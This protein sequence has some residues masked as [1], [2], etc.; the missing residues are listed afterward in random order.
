MA[1]ILMLDTATEVCS[2][3]LS[4]DGMIN[5]FREENEGFRHSE[6]LTVFIGEVLGEAGWTT[7][8]LDAVCVSRGPGSYTGL[9]IGISV[10]K[11]ICYGAGIPLVSVSSL[12]SMADYVARHLPDLTGEELPD[13]LL[14]PMLDAR[15]MEVYSTLCDRNG[16]PV[17]GLQAIIVN[18]HSFQNEL[19][20]GKIVFFGNGAAK[21]RMIIQHPNALFPA[22]IPASARFMSRLAHEHFDQRQFEDVAYFEPFYLKDFVATVPRNKIF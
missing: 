13:A 20:K 7:G 3:A 15:R 8:S 18:D 19:N 12:H 9:R 17:T 1:R 2:V 6:K 22:D 10:A 16:K 5:S 14:C 21:C 4:E 11:G